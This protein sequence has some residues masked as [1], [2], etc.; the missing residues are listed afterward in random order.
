MKWL[1]SFLLI[2][3]AAVVIGLFAQE[4]NGYILIGRGYTTVEMSLTLFLLLIIFLFLLGYALLRIFSGTWRLP[5]QLKMWQNE[6]KS[7]K[8]RK[9]SMR[10]LVELAQGNWAQAERAL[11]KHV[12]NSETPLLNYLSAARAA[13]KLNAPDRRDQYLSQAHSTT[14]GAD[15]AVKLTQAELQLTH[16]QYEL[17][18]AT[19]IHLQSISP[20]HPHIL[21]LLA[22]IYQ[23][24]QC[25]GDVKSLLPK[26][27]KYKVFAA[28]E[29]QQ[30]EKQVQLQLL[31]IA[32]DKHEVETLEGS[33]EHISKELRRDPD[34]A[35]CYAAYL[36]ELNEHDKAE[37]ILRNSLRKKWCDDLLELFGRLN[38]SQPEKTLSIAETWAKDHEN[39]P[40]L[41]LALGRLSLRCK[42]WG[43]A[44]SYLEASNGVKPSAEGY[45]ELGA[46]LERLDE[47]SE[48][49]KCYREG[50]LLTHD[51]VANDYFDDA[52]Q[53]LANSKASEK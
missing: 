52:I 43:K 1:L 3:S 9:S 50:L 8:A 44:R 27:R 53:S 26:L 48:A 23:K 18:L 33:W 35:K 12:N 38:T 7:D 28:Q 29:L 11:L 19:L 25:W 14:K 46:L 41:L 39:N 6:R 40:Q 49:A 30:L 4:D 31:R 10:G 36:I 5:E 20:S 17:A 42:L 22:R 32:A 34:L 37:Q 15:F 16:G 2:L 13:Q 47:N 21:Y 45:R 51:R 24:L